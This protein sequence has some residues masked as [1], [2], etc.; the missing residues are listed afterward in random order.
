MGFVSDNDIL[1]FKDLE[2]KTD[3]DFS[4]LRLIAQN[5]TTNKSWQFS[6][7]KLINVSTWTARTYYASPSIVLYSGNLYYCK[8]TIPFTS[9]NFATELAAGSWQKFSFKSGYGSWNPVLY[10]SG[11]MT[12]SASV[13]YAYNDRIATLCGVI[14]VGTISEAITYLSIND[15]P[16]IITP[17]S[18]Q[19]SL[20][21]VQMYGHGSAALS[22]HVEFD[23]DNIEIIFKR[24]DSNGNEAN[25]CPDTDGE[26]IR[27]S[28]TY[29]IY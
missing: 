13:Q 4:G 22:P 9:T 1:Y 26:I 17:Y 2:E 20:G 21:L 29:Q 5:V 16:S 3:G 11:S 12:Y 25:L 10:I 8:A 27:F 6:S 23:D 24:L 28:L 7:D 14:A 19:K 15:F 18:V